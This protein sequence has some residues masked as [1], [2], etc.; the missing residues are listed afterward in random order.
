MGSR[1]S[2]QNQ[3]PLRVVGEVL[4]YVWD[5]IGIAGMPPGRDDYDGYVCPVFSLLRS[6]APASAIAAHL[7]Y[8]ADKRMGLPGQ[9][10]ASENAANIL[11]DWREHLQRTD[12]QERLAAMGLLD[13]LTS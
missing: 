8:V 3:A 12:V 9:K 10:E 13:V 6:G 1:L 11:I 2:Q 5:P 7:E 4:H